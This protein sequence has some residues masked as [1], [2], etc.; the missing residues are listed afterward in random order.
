M[1]T[2]AYIANQFPSPVEPYVID[3][4]CELRRRG[5]NV[6][7]V[8]AQHID[9][10]QLNDGLR[11]FCSSSI[12][13]DRPPVLL[14]I[15]A[16][17]L[18]IR[19]LRLISDV[20]WRILTGR[21]TFRRKI[22]AV[23]HT[24][25]GACLA[26][27]LSGYDVEHIHTHHGYFASWVAMVAAR[28][29]NISFSMT[30]HGSDLLLHGAYLDLKLASCSTCYTISEYN[31]R[32]IRAHYPR[33]H[34]GKVVLQRMG[35]DSVSPSAALAVINPAQFTFVAV[36]R[37]HPVKNFEFLIECCRALRAE[38]FEFCCR[39]AGEGPERSKLE[40]LCRQSGLENHVLFLGHVAQQDLA[41]VYADSDIVL[42][43]SR[44]E[45]IPLSLMEAMVR[46]KVVLAPRIT[47]IPELVIQ[48]QT[49][50]LYTPGSTQDF[51]TKLH[52]ICDSWQQLGDVR[53][54]ARAHVLAHFNRETNLDRFCTLLLSNLMTTEGRIS[55]ANPVLQQ[56]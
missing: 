5:I 34:R 37:L 17:W 29:L 27:Q 53:C 52:F 14:L 19:K 11:D 9:T 47:G 24:C 22:G 25:L 16:L 39:I 20:C 46:S 43:T 31:L 33:A 35:V 1:P 13:L 50:F 7:T 38:N 40:R 54:A 51:L 10:R 48:G 49:G 3:E 56:I 28:L 23:A 55:H 36:G 2:I 15:S 30:L 41:G 18:C 26:L 4:V 12:V 32:F 44:S 6:I 21:E 42:C 8:S 45:G